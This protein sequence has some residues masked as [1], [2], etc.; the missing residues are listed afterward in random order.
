MSN[1]IKESRLLP[2]IY[3]NWL[4]FLGNKPSQSISEY[5]LFSDAVIT[6]ENTTDFGPYQFLNPCP[7]RA[8]KIRPVLIL[9]VDFRLSYEFN[10]PCETDFGYY[11]GGNLID[12][13]AAFVSLCLGA[14]FKAGGQTREFRENGDRF[15]RP[16]QYAEKIIP[17]VF[18]EYNI[19]KLPYVLGL[20]EISYLDPLRYILN[21]S[22]ENLI[23]LIRAAR[24]Y[25]DSLWIAESEPSL[26]WV[27]LVSAIEVVAHQWKKDSE[28][29]EELLEY[30]KPDLY[31]FLNAE[32][33]EKEKINKIAEQLANICG[34]TRKFVDF[35]LEFMPP[36]PI[37]RAP[38][39]FQHS[40]EKDKMKDSLRKIYDHRS[41]ALHGGIPFPFSMCEAPYWP[42]GQEAPAEIPI[43]LGTFCEGGSWKIE[44]TPLV[45]NTFEYIV[46]N[47]LLN[48][49]KSIAASK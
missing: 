21:I 12:E 34:S 35:T 43:G 29:S 15:G 2:P 42:K 37:E 18:P 23:A 47:C 16:V 31:K 46:R 36:A 28:S 11:H 39:A 7:S 25:Q 9:R 8:T 49:M 27:M 33:K 30:S 32:I 24:L 20:R 17:N 40:W 1:E 38:P 5:P 14:R 45:L 4:A 10:R 19:Y 44:D 13:I 26:A 22:E 41:N 3:E 48:W 6:G